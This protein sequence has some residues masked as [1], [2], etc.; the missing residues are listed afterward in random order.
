MECCR[1]L[2]FRH[3]TEIDACF[4]FKGKDDGHLRI[5]ACD[6]AF[7]VWQLKKLLSYFSRMICSNDIIQILHRF[8][9]SA[10]TSGTRK[11]DDMRKLR[12]M[13]LNF[14]RDPEGVADREPFRLFSGFPE[15]L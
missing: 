4:I 1:K 2:L 9:R 8:P 6:H 10:E 11:F 13:L 7:D 14:P 12:K 15:R 3:K 5:S